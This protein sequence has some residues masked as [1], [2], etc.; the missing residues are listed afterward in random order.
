[1]ITV[2][3]YQYN[4]HIGLGMPGD[5]GYLRLEEEDNEETRRIEEL[6]R[7]I[8]EDNGDEKGEAD[9]QESDREKVARMR[10]A[11]QRKTRS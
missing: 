7:K 4:Q 5:I 1:M 9:E 11:E 10:V 3:C 8:C 2:E 6:K